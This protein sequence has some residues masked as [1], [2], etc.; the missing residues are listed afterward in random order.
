VLSRAVPH[1]GRPAASRL[2]SVP[3]LVLQ[4]RCACGGAP[5][6]D[7]E[8]A[9]CKARRLQRQAAGGGPAV[10]PPVVHEVLG[11]PGRPL[12]PGVRGEMEARFGHDF[13][14]VR[15]HTDGRAAAS[16]RAV[17]AAA[18]TVGRDVVFGA[19]RFRPGTAEGRSLLAHE[20]AHVAQQAGSGPPSRDLPVQPADHPAEREA[21]RG[22]FVAARQ[23]PA[24]QRACLPAAECR[25][26]EG[27]LT[28]FVQEAE[29]QPAYVARRTKRVT[30]CSPNPKSSAC[31]GD[32]HGAPA[33]QLTAFLSANSPARLSLI[34]GIYVDK[35][36][37]AQYGA[38]T[39]ACGDFTPPLTGGYCTFVPD[40]LESQAAVYNAASSNTI[41]RWDRTEWRTMA[42]TTLTHETEHA[43]F[44]SAAPI[45]PGVCDPTPFQWDLSELAA[46]TAGFA[47][48]YR[49][50][51]RKPPEARRADLDAYFRWAV[52]IRRHGETIGGIVRFVR[53]QCDC[54]DA[55]AYIRKTVEF[56]T[57]GWNSAELT[58]FH[59]EL[60]DAK[61]GLHWPIAPP[62]AMSVEDL[63]PAIPTMDVE[64]L[65]IAPRIPTVNVEDLPKAR[66]R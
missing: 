44:E 27:S 29:S 25:S 60:G 56:A 66:E 4:R 22:G 55:D 48:A 63:P 32:G 8:C 51:F 46:L 20:L 21:E 37:P 31:I 57:Q 15:V 2:G 38:Y 28:D 13:S 49:R 42:V 33:P 47:I 43:R 12:E 26:K 23:G 5:G 18:Y 65:P 3:A 19:D 59:T 9:A 14:R 58:T 52:P 62:A 6:P 39:S 7:G 61:Y 16:A 11:S 53:C 64:D 17:E 36:I 10:A 30:A 50:S 41:G 40:W 34:T 1:A 45:T 35:D 24:V 54:A